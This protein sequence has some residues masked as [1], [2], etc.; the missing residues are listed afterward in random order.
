MIHI[1]PAGFEHEE[2]VYGVSPQNLPGDQ[3]VL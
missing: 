3:V 2:E 1:E